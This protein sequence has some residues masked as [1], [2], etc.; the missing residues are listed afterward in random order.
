MNLSINIKDGSVIEAFGMDWTIRIFS[1]DQLGNNLGICA[2]DLQEI[3]LLDE[4]DEKEKLQTLCHEIGH[5]VFF[6]TGLKQAI[7]HELEEV[8][9]ENVSMGIVEALYQLTSKKKKVSKRK[10]S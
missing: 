5:A 7:S 6:R 4:Q 3:W 8:I 1:R 10:R 2:F 9:V